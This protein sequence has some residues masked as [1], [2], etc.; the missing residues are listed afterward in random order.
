MRTTPEGKT[1]QVFIVSAN[2]QV[3]LAEALVVSMAALALG[4][5]Y[6]RCITIQGRLL[7]K[8]L[9]GPAVRCVSSPAHFQA[10]WFARHVV[11]H[12]LP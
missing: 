10:G 5:R 12:C 4:E 2:T 1:A 9:F 6:R 3:P 7:S 8:S 11:W